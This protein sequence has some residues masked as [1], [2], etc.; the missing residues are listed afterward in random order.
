[1]SL[2]TTDV[3]DTKTYA[4]A[5]DRYLAQQGAL[6]PGVVNAGDYVVA[7]R[8]SGANMSVDVAAGGAWVAGGSVA[9]Q[10]LYHQVNDGTVNQTAAAADATNPRIDQVILAINDS[11]AIGISDIPTLTVVAGTP[12]AGATLAN[13]AGADTLA[14]YSSSLRLA[15]ILVPAGATTVVSA[16][17]LDRRPWARGAFV[18]QVKTD[19]NVSTTFQ[20]YVDQARL[21]ARVECS[22]VPLRIS[23]QALGLNDTA[24]ATCATFCQLDGAGAADGA[25]TLGQ[26]TRPGATAGGMPVGFSYV[27]LLSPGSHLFAAALVALN[28]GTAT[29]YCATI[30]PA[31]FTIEE[32]LRPNQANG[33][34]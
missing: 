3:L 22:G 29:I 14:R 17:I 28:G 19:A 26:G 5:A 9:R 16:N 30:N 2:L 15:D 21:Q 34:T 20:A 10:G 31:V 1:V 24:G 7:Q 32:I 23:F 4:A 6:Q 33:T 18:R 8:G 27:T 12:T 13:R 11:T 25:T